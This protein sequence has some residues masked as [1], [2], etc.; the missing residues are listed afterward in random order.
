MMKIGVMITF[1][2]FVWLVLRDYTSMLD[3]M[4]GMAAGA[5][6]MGWI[7]IRGVT[8]RIE[9]PLL[10]ASKDIEQLAAIVEKLEGQQRKNTSNNPL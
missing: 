6:A 4:A 1:I 2:L 8:H 3:F 7:A 10:H 9:K 5:A